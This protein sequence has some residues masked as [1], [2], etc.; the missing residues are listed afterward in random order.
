MSHRQNVA[1]PA[2]ATL[3]GQGTEFPM[4]TIPSPATSRADGRADTPP[5]LARL[6]A[7]AAALGMPACLIAVDETIFMVNAAYCRLSGRLPE[8][9][10]GRKICEIIGGEAYETIRPHLA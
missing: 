8:Q 10:E 7:G 1:A 2:C 6:R 5:E 9:V 4:A 3:P